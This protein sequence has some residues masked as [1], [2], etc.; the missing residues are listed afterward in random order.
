M[1][2]APACHD[3]RGWHGKLV[4]SAKNYQPR[5]KPYITA[6]AIKPK[7]GGVTD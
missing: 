4:T 3:H 5:A 1:A 2:Y 6:N 7:A